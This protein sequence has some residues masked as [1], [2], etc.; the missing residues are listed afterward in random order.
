MTTLICVFFYVC[1]SIYTSTLEAQCRGLRKS[2]QDT[3]IV[4][5]LVACCMSYDFSAVNVKIYNNGT[6]QGFWRALCKSESLF[7]LLNSSSRLEPMRLI[8]SRS[9]A[10]FE[11]CHPSRVSGLIASSTTTPRNELDKREAAIKIQ[12]GKHVNIDMEHQFTSH[13]GSSAFKDYPLMIAST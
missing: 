6:I 13:S 2:T 3:P 11:V 8:R 1:C 7:R 9:S 5:L 10:G 4:C 12:P